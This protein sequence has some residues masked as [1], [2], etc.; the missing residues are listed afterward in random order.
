MSLKEQL[1]GAI[2]ARL[3]E[4]LPENEP[5]SK[6]DLVAMTEDILKEYNKVIKKAKKDS[7]GV[8][9]PDDPLERRKAELRA[10][11]LEIE[12]DLPLKG[13]IPNE[14]APHIEAVMH[15]IPQSTKYRWIREYKKHRQAGDDPIVSYLKLKAK[16]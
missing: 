14:E 2:E 13:I 5:I 4:R 1:V 3:S 10:M 9:V 6:R 12:G 11:F 7:Q 16:H 15:G 8:Q